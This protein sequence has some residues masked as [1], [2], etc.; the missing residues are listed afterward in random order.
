VLLLGLSLRAI[1]EA[2]L[3]TG[4]VEMKAKKKRNDRKQ[5]YNKCKERFDNR[6]TGIRRGS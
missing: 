6:W 1:K 5:K 2:A 4:L 3:I